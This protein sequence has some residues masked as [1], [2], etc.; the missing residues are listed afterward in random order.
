MYYGNLLN[1]GLELYNRLEHRIKK[2]MRGGLE[3][4]LSFLI[5]DCDNDNHF[6][7]SLLVVNNHRAP[8][9]SAL[10]GSQ[11]TL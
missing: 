9:E 7:D 10:S 11:A 6:C 3:V 2:S 4:V 5:I 8:Y 1:N